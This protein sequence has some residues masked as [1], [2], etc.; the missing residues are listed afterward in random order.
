MPTPRVSAAIPAYNVA[1]YLADA[2]ESVLA[3]TRPPDEIVVVDDGS[4]DGTPDVCR[5]YGSAIRYVRREHDDTQGAGARARAFV[6]ATGDWIALLDADDYWLPEKLE[7]QLAAVAAHPDAGVVFTDYFTTGDSAGPAPRLDL[8]GDPVVSIPSHEAFHL[9]LRTMTFSASSALVR[10]GVV[11]EAGLAEPLRDG[12]DDWEL[13]VRIA[14][15]LPV[16][17]VREPLTAYR[18]RAGQNTENKERLARRLA[19]SVERHGR[20]LHPGCDECRR[21]HAAGRSAVRHVAGVAARD[22]LDDYHA[23]TRA[24]RLRDGLG[25][26]ARAWR[27]RPSELLRPRRV[28]AVGKT[29]GLATATALRRP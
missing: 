17:V 26:L 19:M 16:V 18:M 1:A 29:L 8:G 21:S 3:Q 5:S 15:R 4:T 11:A 24:G 23:A 9:F 10:R 7:R 25:S 2:L 28:A 20:Y 22:L 6:E 27:A 12:T 13:W 14:R